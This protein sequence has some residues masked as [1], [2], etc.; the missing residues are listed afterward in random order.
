M[1]DDREYQVANS[2]FVPLGCFEDVVDGLLIRE[3]DM[4]P[5]TV[6]E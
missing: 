4:P 3:L 2:V 6:R 1:A 5:E